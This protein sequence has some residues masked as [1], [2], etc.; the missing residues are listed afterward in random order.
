MPFLQ[1]EGLILKS[2]IY[3]YVQSKPQLVLLLLEGHF[4]I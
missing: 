3:Q 1:N 4:W 2:L